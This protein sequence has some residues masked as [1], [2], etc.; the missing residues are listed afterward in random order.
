M[1]DEGEGEAR[2]A[3][4]DVSQISAIV[5]Y[6]DRFVTAGQRCGYILIRCSGR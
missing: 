2:V 5:R 3:R 6:R 4:E 1:I